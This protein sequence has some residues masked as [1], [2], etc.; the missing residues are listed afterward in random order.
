MTT[1]I[2]VTAFNYVTMKYVMERLLRH[3]LPSSLNFGGELTERGV[4][5][6]LYKLSL[7]G[8]IIVDSVGCAGIPR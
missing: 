2:L 1:A 5:L 8:I 3:R 6:T 7:N 4:V